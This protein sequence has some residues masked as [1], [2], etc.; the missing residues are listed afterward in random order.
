MA[1]FAKIDENNAVI[2]VVAVSNNV[3]TDENGVEQES[4][5]IEFLKKDLNEI[6]TYSSI[7]YAIA[8]G[9]NKIGDIANFLNLKSTYLTRY[10]Q[11]LIDIMIIKKHVPLNENIKKSTITNRFIKIIYFKSNG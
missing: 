2:K 8:L 3:I 1:H 4:L 10:M 5:G 7:L 9:N 6:S 11:K